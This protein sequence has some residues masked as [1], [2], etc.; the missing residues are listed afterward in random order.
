MNKS[1]FGEFG[2]IIANSHPTLGL[3]VADKLGVTPL[4]I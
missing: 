2:L 3:E 4:L 1:R